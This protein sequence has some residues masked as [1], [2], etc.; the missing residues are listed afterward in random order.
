MFTFSAFW[1]LIRGF[2]LY[3]PREIPPIQRW[4]LACGVWV[5]YHGDNTHDFLFQR[6]TS[7][8][9]LPNDCML[10]ISWIRRTPSER[11]FIRLDIGGM[12][13][14]SSLV[15]N[16]QKEVSLSAMTYTCQLATICRMY[17]PGYFET[18]FLGYPCS[19]STSIRNASRFQTPF[20][21]LSFLHHGN[22]TV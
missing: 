2:L 9:D 4:S 10:T 22:Y 19:S 21:R 16:L 12:S 5:K 7:R 8:R 20:A 15:F 18:W 13:L 1:T 17:A 6:K 3:R 14:A 11:S